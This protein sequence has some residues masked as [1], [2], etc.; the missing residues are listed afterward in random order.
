[1]YSSDIIF[2]FIDSLTLTRTISYLPEFHVF[3]CQVCCVSVRRSQFT[4]HFRIQHR[5]TSV[6][7]KA[8]NLFCGLIVPDSD[9][10]SIETVPLY[11][12]TAITRLPVLSNGLLCQINRTKCRYICRSSEKMRKHCQQTHRWQQKTDQ[13]RP[14]TAARATLPALS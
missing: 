1:M 3:L 8:L 4:S 2:G 9:V 14:S 13:G 11:V 6:Q 12:E 10:R 7:L 5:F